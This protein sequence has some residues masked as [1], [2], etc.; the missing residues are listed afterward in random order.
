VL[1]VRDS[2]EIFTKINELGKILSTKYPNTT[3]KIS[4]K[5]ISD[6]ENVN[7]LQTK[8][9]LKLIHKYY[10]K[11]PNI[12][13]IYIDSVSREPKQMFKYYGK[14]Y[15]YSDKIVI[16]CKADQRYIPVMVASIIAKYHANAETKRLKTQYDCGGGHPRDYKTL[17]YMINNMDNKDEII[18]TGWKPYKRLQSSK[19]LRQDIKN[20]IENGKI[21]QS[22]LKELYKN[23]KV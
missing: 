6:S 11:H 13:K 18:R 21:T 15:K 12:K 16:E 20:L 4:A 3:F 8:Y 23:A 10:N 14:L 22:K 1:G 7:E 9:I 2:K 5:E 19:Q 17:Y